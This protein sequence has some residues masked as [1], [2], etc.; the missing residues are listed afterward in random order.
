MSESQQSSQRYLTKSRFKQAVECPRKLIYTGRAEY[1]DANKTN[2][3]LKGLAEGGF[4][5]GALAQVIYAKKAELEGI[6]WKEIKGDQEG[7]IKQTRD[8]LQQSNITL[9]EA[10][11]QVESFLVRVDI[12]RKRGNRLDLI[13]VKSKSVDTAKTSVPLKSADYLPYLQDLAYQTMVLRKAYPEFEVHS[14][15]MMPDKAK[16]TTSNNLHA[17]FPVRLLVEN[18]KQ[19]TEVDTPARSEWASIDHAFMCE[20]PAD[21]DVSDV[22]NGT[23][24]TQAPGIEGPF[25]SLAAQWARA[26]AQQIDIEPAI[27][28][29]NCGGCE[30]YTASPTE[31]KRSGFHE[32]WQRKVKGFTAEETRERTVLGLYNDR[33]GVKNEQLNKKIY[34]LH[35]IDRADLKWDPVAGPISNAQRQWMQISNTWPGGGGFYF[36]RAGFA[37][38]QEN[39][40]Y[41]Y[42]FLDFE[43]ARSA[44]PVRAGQRPNGI[45]AF[46]YSLHLMHEDG[47][48]EHKH[49]FIKLDQ[50]GNPNVEF[51]RDLK[52]ALGSSGTVFRWHEYEKTVLN[53]LR[54][55]LV[56][57]AV[58]D[59][60]HEELIIFIDSLVNEESPRYMV[61]QSKIAQMY[62]FHP[63]TRGS[64]SIKKV[65]PAMMNSSALLR[66]IY[67]EA[68]YGV[69]AQIPSL[70]F[71][72][73]IA[74]WQPDL[75]NPT[76][77][78][79]PYDLLADLNLPTGLGEEAELYKAAER[80]LNEEG[81]ALRDGGGAMMA[82]LRQQSGMLGADEK[83]RLKAAMLRYCELDTLAMVMI[84]Q[85]WMHSN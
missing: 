71:L 8:A 56:A 37:S 42:C 84:M 31:T 45:N 68:I 39:W 54:R 64:S 75:N 47:H 27:G 29:K 76:K 57:A 77:A 36:D 78:V 65:L 33:S 44:L 58:K 40:I 15:L 11:I 79:D 67:R 19:T 1:V 16:A 21:Q 83:E 59:P 28:N 41:P 69:D 62:F 73:P 10:T 70:N 2:D 24:K 22:L 60:D 25:Q 6:P 43:A 74:W 4:Q 9:F 34:Y 61:D 85:G 55:E 51:L 82:Y 13:E 20:I 26:Y 12:L 63:D 49:Q 38:K 23:L 53:E 66:D 48:V 30:Y 81:A 32:C 80:T 72:E 3:L 5:I 14:Y 7:Q 50:T 17:L 18:G 35:K 46:Q 52:K